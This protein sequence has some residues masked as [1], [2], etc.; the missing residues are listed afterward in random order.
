MNINAGQIKEHRVL[1]LVE[2]DED[3]ARIIQKALS[4]TIKA[5]PHIVWVNNGQKA[6]NYVSRSGTYKNKRTPAPGLVLLDIKLPIK[7]GFEVLRYMRDNKQYKDIPVI[8]LSTSSRPEDIERALKL[9]AKDYIVKP[10]TFT[11]FKRKMKE[12]GERWI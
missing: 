3:H 10:N 2:D 4:L 12:V 8:T 1:L 7:D 6:I 5:I 9:G 11:E